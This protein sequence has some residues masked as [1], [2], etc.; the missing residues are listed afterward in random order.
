MLTT[1][2]D[3]EL[4]RLRSRGIV[5]LDYTGAAPYPESVAREHVQTLGE[6][7]FGNP[8]STHPASLRSTRAAVAARDALLAFLDGDPGEYEVVWTANASAALRLIGESFPFDPETPFVLT[9]DN[10]NTVNGIRMHAVARGAAV[11]YLPLDADLRVQPFELT[12]VRQGLFAFPA[13]SNFSGAQHPLEWVG[14]AQARGYRVL[15]DVAAYVPAHPFSLRE[16]RPDFA[17]LSIYKMCGYPTGVGALI[18]RRDALRCLARPAFSGGTV[19][20]VSVLTNRHLL[21]PGADGFE[22][23]TGNYLAWSAV[24]F[25]LRLLERLSMP[26]IE[27]HVSR[28][29]DRLLRGLTALRHPGGAPALQIHGPDVL[30]RRGGTIAF[31]L[32][33]AEGVVIDYEEVVATAADQGICL[34]GGCFCN[35]GCAERAFDYSAEE[36]AR[37]LDAVG[38]AFSIPAMRTAL[39]N[40]PVGAIRASLGYGSHAGDVDA[41]L[42]FLHQFIRREGRERRERREGREGQEGRRV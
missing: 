6:E 42:E 34:R 12:S 27:E 25:G 24:P 41:L 16:V 26:A 22:D 28:L 1:I 3:H 35:P 21:K 31:N 4:S 2:R 23:G 7:V 32:L 14:L 5:Y 33:D 10:H 29:T 8:H 39:D 20:F 40:K 37:A 17:A 30:E 13:Q 18:A 38:N 15:L 36:L 9:A 19:E 11:R